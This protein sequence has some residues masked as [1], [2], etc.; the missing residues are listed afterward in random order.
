LFIHDLALH[1]ANQELYAPVDIMPLLNS[2]SNL[3]ELSVDSEEEERYNIEEV[4]G[5]AVWPS[6]PFNYLSFLKSCLYT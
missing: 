5:R 3:R 6:P 1:L 4:F 2:M